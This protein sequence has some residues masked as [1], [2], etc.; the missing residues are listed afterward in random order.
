MTILRSFVPNN[1]DL[2]T[3]MKFALDEVENIVEKGE[4]AD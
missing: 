2:A 1:L 3:M 4:I